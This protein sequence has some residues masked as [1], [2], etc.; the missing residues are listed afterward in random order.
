MQPKKLW[1]TLLAIAMI[2]LCGLMVLVVVFSFRNVSLPDVR[3]WNLQLDIP[4]MAA[5]AD[6][7][8]SFTVSTPAVLEV[9]NPFGDITVEGTDGNEIKVSVHKEAHG[10]DRKSA[11][12]NLKNLVINFTQEGNTVKIDVPEPEGRV[13]T[14]AY[15]MFTIEVPRETAVT[16]DTKN[17]NVEATNLAGNTVLHSSFGGVTIDGLQNGSLTATSE[18]GSVTANGIK[19]DGLPIELSSSFGKIELTGAAASVLTATSMNGEVTLSK[20]N[21]TGPVT[22]ENEF[23][24][25]AVD[26]LTGQ[27]VDVTA[28]NGSIT[29]TGARIE[30]T[31]TAKNDFGDITLNNTLSGSYDLQNQNGSIKLDKASGT[32]TASSDF[33]S[34]EIFNGQACDLNLT[35]SNG[36]ISYEGSL[37]AGPHTLKSDFGS[38]DLSLPS[39]SALTVDLK[40]EFGEINNSFEITT[41]GSVKEHHQSGKINGGGA[42]L[43]IQVD[44]GS[45]TLEKT[46]K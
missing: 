2:A 1:I 37:G 29:L 42:G 14:T 31:L 11:E 24:Q 26:D 45:I 21:V 23:G 36:S 18:N 43:N 22:L 8:K 38:I 17:G 19:S 15:A 39:D 9:N 46:G 3:S 34:I 27:S 6:E 20:V 41:E 44:N 28:K 25:V 35:T 16:L 40:T 4:A 13:I 7:T 5:S 32:V 10:I 33:G 30:K 12:E